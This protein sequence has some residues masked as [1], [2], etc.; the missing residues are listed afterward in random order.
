VGLRVESGVGRDEGRFSLFGMHV[1]ESTEAA[2]A[3]LV[4]NKYLYIRVMRVMR[5]MRVIIIRGIG[6]N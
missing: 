1:S 2:G 3:F 4:V 6:Q 5:V